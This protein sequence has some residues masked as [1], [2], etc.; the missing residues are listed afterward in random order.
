MGALKKVGTAGF[1]AAVLI[2]GYHFLVQ[3]LIANKTLPGFYELG[4]FMLQANAAEAHAAGPQGGAPRK[5]AVH[6]RNVTLEETDT[7][8]RAIGTGRSVRTTNL[9]P[10]TTGRV[11][12]IAYQ[13]GDY[14]E[15][16]QTVITLD[17]ANEELA[18]KQ[19]ELELR[20]AIDQVDRYERLI[21]SQTISE[22]QLR[23]ARTARDKAQL[24]L[25]KAQLDLQ[26]RKIVAP[27][28][29]TL[30]IVAVEVG[31][32]V[33][34][35][36]RLTGLDDRNK[37]L[38]EFVVPERFANEVS[39][40]GA[41]ELATD[42]VPGRQFKGTITA[43]DNRVDAT[44]RTLRL[45]AQVSNP[46][47]LLKSGM[48]F[49]VRVLLEG[50]SWTA[51]PPLALKWDQQGAYVWVA[52]AQKAERVSVRIIERN[53]D[54]ILVD[55]DLKVGEVVITEA[56]RGLRPGAPLAL[57]AHPG[58]SL[59]VPSGPADGSALPEA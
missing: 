2:A 55:G 11:T 17:K 28:S 32:L 24:A 37:I 35:S 16:G 19:A 22:V 57:E 18:V 6:A 10:E 50:E 39:R 38:V 48:A 5:I 4:T 1:M 33:D 40:G 42:A 52:R 26:K 51:I 46:E 36:T 20:D 47:G 29:G 27:F 34:A 8:V 3:P 58:F 15:A 21:K 12:T 54:S 56:T 7:F 45:R 14:V 41:V 23:D 59:K 49:S 53:S 31:D 43:L 30:G 25:E 13:A 9:Y 44:S